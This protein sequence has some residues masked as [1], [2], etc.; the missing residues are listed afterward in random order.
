MVTFAPLQPPSTPPAAAMPVIAVA[1]KVIS[2]KSCDGLY[3]GPLIT[4]GRNSFKRL[5]ISC[6]IFLKIAF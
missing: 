4:D 6:Q 3:Q 2:Y 5:K 1:A